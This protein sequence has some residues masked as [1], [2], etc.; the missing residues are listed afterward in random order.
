MK[1][2]RSTLIYALFIFLLTCVAGQAADR[3]VLFQTS[4][5]QALMNG[6]YDGDYSFGDLQRHGDF[7]LGTFQALDGEMVAVDGRFYQVKTDGAAYPVAPTQKTP[8][9]EVTFFRADKT[10]NLTEPLDLKQLEQYLTDRLPSMNF[11]YAIR[12]TGKFSFI[13]TRSVPRQAR[14]YPLLVEVVKNQAVFEFREVDGVIV[15]FYHPKY[16]A[17]INVAGYHLHFLTRDHRAGGHLLD[18]R[19]KE[20]RVELDRMDEV[21]LRL[22]GN[23]A[24]SQTDLSGDKRQDIQKVER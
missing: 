7:G 23:A 3:K 5:I 6:V 1:I 13:R 12:I 10:L 22:P 19:I 11:P 24:F 16:L 20:A 15:G 2:R 9:S 18:C 8:F 14:P 21:H 17:G 4:T